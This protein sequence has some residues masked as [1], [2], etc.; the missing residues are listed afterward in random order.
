[1]AHRR[2]VELVIMFLGMASLFFVLAPPSPA[3]AGFTIVRPDP[4]LAFSF[5]PDGT[6]LGLVTPDGVWA[7]DMK[8]GSKLWHRP[9]S[10]APVLNGCSTL[11]F[12]S[13]GGTMALSCDAAQPFFLDSATGEPGATWEGAATA[14]QR[15][16]DDLVLP[17]DLI[18]EGEEV[19]GVA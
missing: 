11:V 5:S 18:P 19:R 17:A 16:K 3:K 15:G 6:R 12:S 9:A 2:L 14:S 10:D 1:M 8:A 13:D 7:F 4:G